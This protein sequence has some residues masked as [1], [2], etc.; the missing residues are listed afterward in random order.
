MPNTPAVRRLRDAGVQNRLAAR[1]RQVPEERAFATIRRL[2]AIEPKAGQ[3]IANRLLHNRG[4]LE[5]LL[6]EG[7]VVGNPSTINF[8]LEA[9]GKRLGP[10]HLVQI[11]RE[12]ARQDPGI[13]KGPLI[14]SPGSSGTMSRPVRTSI[15]FAPTLCGGD[16]G[17]RA[18][19]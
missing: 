14:R 17:I 3:Q 15:N 4:F 12:Q 18:L 10:L 16:H 11:V 5:Q 1:L 19:L 7:L 6:R 13:G 9:V 2:I 8:W